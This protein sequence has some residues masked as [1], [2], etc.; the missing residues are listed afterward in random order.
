M[1]VFGN[2]LV[3]CVCESA[4]LC[5]PP[6]PCMTQRMCVCVCHEDACV[7]R[8]RRLRR[9]GATVVTVPALIDSAGGVRVAN[10]TARQRRRGRTLT[11]NIWQI[12]DSH[13]LSAK[14]TFLCISS[15]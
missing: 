10:V 7:C 5:L 2:G 13:C 11:G 1:Y 15:L 8:R 9:R 12:Y 14:D 3:S 4:S 6:S